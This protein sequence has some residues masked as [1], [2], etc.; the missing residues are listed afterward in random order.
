METWIDRL[1]VALDLEPL[2][3]SE[4]EALLLAAREVAHGVE[5]R[6]TPLTTFLAG[7]AVGR[8]GGEGSREASLARVLGI[9]RGNVEDPGPRGNA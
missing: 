4:V 5:R 8:A 1:A 9:V 7:M 2:A 3:P 6:V